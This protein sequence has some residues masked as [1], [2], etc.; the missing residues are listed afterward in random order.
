MKIYPN[1]AERAHCRLCDAP[2]AWVLTFPKRNRCPINRPYQFNQLE[3]DADGHEIAELVSP[4]HFETCPNYDRDT[5]QAK[6][7]A[8]PTLHQQPRLF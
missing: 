2:I 4:T 8:R 5:K 7:P 1:S 6:P 3:Y